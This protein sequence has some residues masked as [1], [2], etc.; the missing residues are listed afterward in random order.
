MSFISSEEI[1]THL[2]DEQVDAISGE[3]ETLLLAAIDGAEAEAKGYLPDFDLEAIF[4]ET[5]TDRHALLVIFVKDIAVWHFINLASPGVD[6]SLREK[7]Y[8]AAIAWLKGVKAGDIVPDLPKVT[9]T[10]EVSGAVT[11]GSNPQR[12]N[13]I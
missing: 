2:Y 13:H 7:R 11:Y 4:A 10:D 1:I 12:D 6:L 3:D 9:P 8:N 5:G